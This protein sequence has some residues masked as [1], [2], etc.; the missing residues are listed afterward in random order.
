[1]QRNTAKHAAQHSAHSAHS[2]K[3]HACTLRFQLSAYG[4]GPS[5]R[6]PGQSHKTL[7]SQH[8][9]MQSHTVKPAHTKGP[10]TDSSG[11]KSTNNI[12]ARR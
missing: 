5:R 9:K 4:P 11:N 12:M 2:A 6:Q 7:E 10:E 3:R 8:L 1:M